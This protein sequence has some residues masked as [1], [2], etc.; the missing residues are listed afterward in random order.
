MY[1][2]EPYVVVVCSPFIIFI[3]L[4]VGVLGIVAAS[5]HLF[6]AC[7]GRASI[8]GS[9]VSCLSRLPLVEACLSANRSR[10]WTITTRLDELMALS[11]KP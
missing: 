9:V 7:R 11:P 3:G 5:L 4:P 10:H 1:S 6:E 2:D 8:V